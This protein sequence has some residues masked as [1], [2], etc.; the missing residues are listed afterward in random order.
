MKI[1]SIIAKERSLQQDNY[2]NIL[3]LVD[4]AKIQDTR[5]HEVTVFGLKVNINIEIY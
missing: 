1:H 2:T 5:D 3:L 4:K